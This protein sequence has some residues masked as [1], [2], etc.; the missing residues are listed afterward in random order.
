AGPIVQ[1]MSERV[2]EERPDSLGALR[3]LGGVGG[4]LGPPTSTD[5]RAVA[6]DARSLEALRRR[7]RRGRARPRDG[8][9]RGARADRPERR[10]Q[11][12]GLQP[13][14]GLSPAR[15]GRYPLPRRLAAGPVATRDLPTRAGAHVPDR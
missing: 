11:D 1:T 3:A 13:A 12:D 7:A 14:V 4:H 15:R 9:G 10:G 2:A 6:R 8:R 5:E